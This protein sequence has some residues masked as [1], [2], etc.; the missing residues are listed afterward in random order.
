MFWQQQ[1]WGAM[2]AKAGAG[3]QPMPFRNLTAERLAAQILDALKP[4]VSTR[5]HDLKVRIAREDGCKVG[6]R[7]FHEHLGQYNSNC[8]LIPSRVAVW[9]E[10]HTGM[11]L[12]ALAATVLVEK[13]LLS[14]QDLVL[15]VSIFRANAVLSY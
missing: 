8:S 7:N 2:V 5:A 11:Q 3:P 13:R 9:R 14:Y 4:E 6:V 15:C 12:S 10:K 1:F